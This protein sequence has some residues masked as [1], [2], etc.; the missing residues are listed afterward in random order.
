MSKSSIWAKL[1]AKGF[2]DTACAAIMGNMQQESAFKPNNVEDRYHADTGK[3]DEYYTAAVDNGSYS[4]NDFMRD[5]G[6]AYGYGL[7]QWT[8]YSRKA[9]LYDF[10]KKRGVSIADEQMQIDW[11]MEE[12]HQSEYSSVYD[13]LMSGTSLKKMT[14]KFMC[15]F[16]NPADQSEC[17]I[18]YRVGLAQAVYTEFAGTTPDDPS[19]DDPCPTPTP[20]P[21]PA[22]P[23]TP[24][25][26]FWPFRGM[27]GGAD[28][29]G[30]CKGMVGCDVLALQAILT[31]QGYGCAADGIFGPITDEKVRQFQSD[32]EALSVD[33]I[34]GRNT[35]AALLTY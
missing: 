2:S 31:C 5:G 35:W 32:T 15:R 10:A 33:G 4:R 21:T 18:N 20:D 7:C 12:M 16:E 6:K 17:A 25:T 8:F 28:D 34:V 19:P 1:K 23:D 11:M 24:D 26:P 3:S 22:D 29:P 9:G 14:E 13:T 30:L 27:K